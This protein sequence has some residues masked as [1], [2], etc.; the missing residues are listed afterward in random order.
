MSK[1][2]I[3]MVRSIDPQALIATA[4]ERGAPIETLERLVQLAKDVRQVTAREA[5]FD[6]MAQFK[7]EC[8]RIKKDA[9]ANAGSYSYAYAT[10]DG[11]LDV[12]DPILGRAG[13][14]ISW[15]QKHEGNFVAAS[16][17]IT[18]R[19][20]HQEESG[21]VPVPFDVTGR[22]NTAQRVGS[23]ATY[24][25][26]Y[27]LLAILGLAP[28]EDDD[29]QGTT[30]GVNAPS[31][32][33]APSAAD[34]GHVSDASPSPTEELFTPADKIREQ[35]I[36]NVRV[37]QS[38]IGPKRFHKIKESLGIVADRPLTAL[39]DNDLAIYERHLE[40]AASKD[41]A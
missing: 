13:L 7:R 14:T 26:R 35:R 32:R 29:A 34:S 25:K 40:Q 21:Y 16:C 23:A 15:R 10:L 27:S 12:V 6:A 18:H 24:A 4:I 31:P 5:Y 17:V 38:K 37:L 22:M 8:P 20:G 1:P 11:I 36:Q 39:S 2:E 30:A 28:E 9:T 41:E 33:G 19:L 3:A